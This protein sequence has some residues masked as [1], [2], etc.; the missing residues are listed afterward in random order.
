MS[1]EV[2]AV[3]DSY[4][5]NGGKMILI[6]SNSSRWQ[7]R[8]SVSVSIDN[9]HGGKTA[10]EYLLSKGISH[11]WTTKY[12]HIP[13]RIDSFI[14]TITKAGKP[15]EVIN[16]DPSKHET[17]YLE[18][19][20]G[21]IE[22]ILMQLERGISGPLGLFI[23][24]D[25]YAMSIIYRLMEKRIKVGTDVLVIGYDGLYSTSLNVPRLTTIAQPFEEVGRQAVKMM[26]NYIYGNETLSALIEPKLIQ[27]DSA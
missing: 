15:V 23:P 18:I 13:E 25:Q 27:G 7:W 26:V 4:H 8:N 5:Q 10:A 12:M 6:E 3:V 2:E 19:V 20:D 16:M 11:A 22:K 17:D 24:S 9:Y 14:S 21:L 1:P